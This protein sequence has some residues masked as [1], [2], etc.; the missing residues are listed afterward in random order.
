MYHPYRPTYICSYST[1]RRHGS[2]VSTVAGCGLEGRRI[3]VGFRKEGR[4][5]YLRCLDRNWGT[6]FCLKLYSVFLEMF[7]SLSLK[8]T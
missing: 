4:D 3:D 2:W 5:F 6:V 1:L 7:Y 8:M